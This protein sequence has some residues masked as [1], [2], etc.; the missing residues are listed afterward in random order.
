MSERE[1]PPHYRRFVRPLN[2]GPEVEI[3]VDEI[4]RAWGLSFRPGCIVKYA[5]RAGQKPGAPEATD[6]AKCKQY[7]QRWSDEMPE[8]VI[9][10]PRE[11]N[12]VLLPGGMKCRRCLAYRPI[13]SP[14][15]WSDWCTVTGEFGR[16]H[17]DCGS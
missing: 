17:E 11:S 12:V 7:A 1:T 10:G 9:D 14:M 3:D 6:R 13:A 16:V 4:I 15:L 5:M 8:D 2:G